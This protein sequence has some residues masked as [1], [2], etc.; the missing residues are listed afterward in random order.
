MRADNRS[1]IAARHI[2]DHAGLPV[3]D[4]TRDPSRAFRKKQSAWA[5]RQIKCA[6]RTHVVTDGLIRR[7]VVGISIQRIGPICRYKP[8]CLCENVRGLKSDT[9]RRLE[10]DLR[11]HRVEVRLAE[12]ANVRGAAELRIRD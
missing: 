12:A 7:S 8:E 5:D 3:L 2:E 11:L 1:R 6:V 4:E 9:L 10:R